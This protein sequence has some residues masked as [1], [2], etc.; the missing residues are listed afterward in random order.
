MRITEFLKKLLKPFKYEI[1][2]S[3]NFFLRIPSKI[4]TYRINLKNKSQV[5][6]VCPKEYKYEAKKIYELSSAKIK[7]DRLLFSQKLG[8]T[9][10]PKDI[11]DALC[12]K[13]V[14][15]ASFVRQKS[16]LT[17]QNLLSS[18]IIKYAHALD[19]GLRMPNKRSK[20][21]E[22]KGEVLEKLMVIWTEQFSTKHPIY[23][24]SR[25]LI[26]EYWVDQEICTQKKKS[27]VYKERD[28]K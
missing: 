7:N 13:K 18:E 26:N 21:G 25:N 24:W 20:F 6:I 12:I 23:I 28:S 4:T 11:Y 8:F 5:S 22:E 16:L 9:V 14:K 3:I 15:K 17:N 27:V 10:I 2:S 1:M 19:K